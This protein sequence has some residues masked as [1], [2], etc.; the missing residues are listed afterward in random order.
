MY[1]L[2][3][4]AQ[5]S[6]APRSPAQP[7]PAMTLPSHAG[8]AQPQALGPSSAFAESSLEARLSPVIRKPQ[9]CAQPQ[10]PQ[11]GS[12]SSHVPG[13][14]SCPATGPARP[15]LAL[16]GSS[17]SPPRQPYHSQQKRVMGGNISSSN[18]ESHTM[19][20]Y[21]LLGFSRLAAFQCVFVSRGFL[22][23][24]GGLAELARAL[25]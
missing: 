21:L 2:L 23:G 3:S 8:P 15:S 16:Q 20:R 22:R 24:E 6:P 11:F 5:P 18:P 9:P 25:L 13:T 14:P 17:D 7:S 10:G 4:P 1:V 19:L 12:P